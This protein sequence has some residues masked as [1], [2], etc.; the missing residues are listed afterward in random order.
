MMHKISFTALAKPTRSQACQPLS[1]S[2]SH[3]FLPCLVP[4]A[5]PAPPPHAVVAYRCAPIDLAT[6]SRRSVTP[7]PSL[8]PSFS[9]GD[10]RWLS[11]TPL[12]ALLPSRGAVYLCNASALPVQAIYLFRNFL[13]FK[14]VIVLAGGANWGFPFTFNTLTHIDT[15]TH[16][17]MAK[18]QLAVATRRATCSRQQSAAQRG[19]HDYKLWKINIVM[20][21]Y[22]LLL[23]TFF[24]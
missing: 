22:K 3:L 11:A 16:G 23:L 2:L 7:T 6:F 18:W 24:I 19:R 17:T 1:R 10:H 5:A 9:L 13:P 8:S 12:L 4:H 15:H 21:A 20:L 14:R